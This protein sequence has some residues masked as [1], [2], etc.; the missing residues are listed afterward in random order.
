[1]REDN[2]RK[3]WSE[4]EL[5]AALAD[6]NNDVAE[7]D[8]GLAFAR[9][10][11]LAAAGGEEAP[12]ETRRAG[13]W[14]WLAVAAAV[15]TLVGG[16]A[17]GASV[18]SSPAPEPARPAVTLPDL[19]RPLAPGEFRYAQKLV[20]VAQIVF[21][22]PAQLQQKI[23]LWIPADPAGVWHRRTMWTGA[24]SGVEAPKVQINLTP[25]DEYGPGGRFPDD[26][27]AG[28]QQPDAAFVAALVPDRAA[29]AKRLTNESSA[30]WK[31][32]RF[33]AT[34][35]L[36]MVRSVLE[37]GLAPK[38]VRLALSQAFGDVPGA[39][40]VPGHAPDGR[41][42]LVLGAKDT[43]QRLYLDQATI[44]LL[45][46]DS[47]VPPPMITR[48]SDIPVTSEAPPPSYQH[49]PVTTTVALPTTTNLRPVVPATV[50]G[51]QAVY[52]FAI[53]RTSG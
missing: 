27:A 43:G 19:D 26:T 11:L 47:P 53:T 25:R 29:L 3:I 39:F 2:V 1:L 13:P 15:V 49:V 50:T 34:D 45:A 42:A 20:W 18:L 44:Q 7:E 28:W 16:L 8:D 14:R 38:D 40:V 52:T 23:E 51:P 10:S 6:L 22:Q 37:L 5:D 41:P 35:S 12:P 24:V 31:D 36:T 4:A 32:N 48:S 21:G 17:V 46:W 33:A 9:A 30:R